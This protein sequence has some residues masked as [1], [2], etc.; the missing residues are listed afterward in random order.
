MNALKNNKS[1]WFEI[2]CV[3]KKEVQWQNEERD[4]VCCHS[5]DEI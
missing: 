5:V 4:R 2:C 1:V 3:E